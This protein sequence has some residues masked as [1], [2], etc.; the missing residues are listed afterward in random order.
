MEVIKFEQLKKINQQPVLSI[1]MFDGVHKGHTLLLEELKQEAVREN[2]CSMVITFDA[3]PRQVIAENENEVRVLQTKE[4]RLE[5]LRRIGVDYVV[6]LHFTKEIARLE[7]SDFLDLVIE[8]LNPKSIVLGYDNRFGR[9]GSTQFD[10]ILAKGE[11]K[12][13]KI[14]RVENCVWH[15]DKEISSTQIR[16]ALEKGEVSLA[17]QMLGYNYSIEGKVIHGYKIGRNLGFPTA[18]IKPTNNKLI[19]PD[20]VYAVR[21]EVDDLMYKG[22]LSIGKRETFEKKTQSIEL[23]IFSFERNIYNKEIKI[24]FKEF[25]REQ[26]KFPTVDDLVVQ[27]KKDCENAKNIL[28]NY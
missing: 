19:P 15:K 14:K 6:I 2:T 28:S 17:N 13:I 24:E 5:R 22:V 10:E 4:Q 21:A 11:Y 23:H 26:K 27:I 8:N 7:A 25:L 3:H 12:T 9:K 18:N 1:G 20:G 16:K